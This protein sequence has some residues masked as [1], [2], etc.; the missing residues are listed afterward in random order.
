MNRNERGIVRSDM[1]HMTM[2]ML[3]GVREMKSQK[4]TGHEAWP[5]AVP[6]PWTMAA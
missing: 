4:V 1:I 6:I 2:C 3:S 5:R